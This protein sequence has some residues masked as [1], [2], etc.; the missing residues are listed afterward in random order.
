MNLNETFRIELSYADAINFV[1][2]HQEAA[3]E[4]FTRAAERQKNPEYTGW[5]KLVHKIN[6]AFD[7]DYKRRWRDNENLQAV[8]EWK[9]MK[10]KPIE[11][12]A[13][14]AH[15]HKTLPEQKKE[16]E[17][18]KPLR[19]HDYPEYS[20]MK[21]VREWPWQESREGKHRFA[22]GQGDDGYY[23]SHQRENQPVN[24]KGPYNTPYD[25]EMAR[26]AAEKKWGREYHGVDKPNGKAREKGK[27]VG[28]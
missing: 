28:L 5:R 12:Y 1:N 10:D 17:A 6:M 19:A 24:W 23:F 11:Q 2:Q 13:S 20:E 3:Q 25:A 16:A 4:L 15:T 21:R 14:E 8:T 18:V 22:T 27:G 26:L 9:P 7:S